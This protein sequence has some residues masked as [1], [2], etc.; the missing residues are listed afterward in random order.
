MIRLLITV[1][2]CVFI[3]SLSACGSQPVVKDTPVNDISVAYTDESNNEETQSTDED[4][5]ITDD[6][7]NTQADNTLHWPIDY[8][9]DLPELNGKIDYVVTSDENR[10]T[11]IT[12]TGVD[13]EDAANYLF[14]VKN[15][16]YS[17]TDMSTSDELFFAGTNVQNDEISFNYNYESKEAFI[18]FTKS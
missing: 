8:M 10:S 4:V 15:L 1:I 2:L 17:G 14:E 6:D 5:T 3:I 18:I 12:I 9:G 13:S 16:G 11:A 7:E